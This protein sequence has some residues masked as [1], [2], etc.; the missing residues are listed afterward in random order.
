MIDITINFLAFIIF[1]IA[2]FLFGYLIPKNEIKISNL[3]EKISNIKNIMANRRESY[4]KYTLSEQNKL[5]DLNTIRILESISQNELTKQH[6][7]ELEKHFHWENVG[8]LGYLFEGSTGQPPQDELKKWDETND[9][10][11]VN[12]LKTSGKDFVSKF[13]ELKQERFQLAQ[14]KHGL[15]HLRWYRLRI[16]VLYQILGLIIL[17]VL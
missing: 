7:K 3:G 13:F 15:E 14:E 16:G 9:S 8:G 10:D 1:G 4:I 2:L 12:E 6:I 11:L 17:Y 5:I